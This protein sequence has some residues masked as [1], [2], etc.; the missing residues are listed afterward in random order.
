M[1]FRCGENSESVN[2]EIRKT[3]GCPFLKKGGDSNLQQRF[4]P[5]LFQK[6]SLLELSQL[7]WQLSL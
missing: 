2:P 7:R 3:L 5:S 1:R 4:N 6:E